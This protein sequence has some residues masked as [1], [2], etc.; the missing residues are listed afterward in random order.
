D[1]RLP[2]RRGGAHDA[3]P[4]PRARP[5]RAEG[6]EGHLA[7]VIAALA[8]AALL[9]APPDTTPLAIIPAPARLERRAG[10]FTLPAGARVR[11]RGRKDPGA[12]AVAAYAD[13]LLEAALGPAPPGA[14]PPRDAIVLRLDAASG[15]ASREAYRLDVGAGG[16]VIS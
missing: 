10:G 5:V 14:R 1:D 11:L 7:A 12:A 13:S 8:L 16:V 6:G 2:E 4:R 3:L 9:Q 15:T